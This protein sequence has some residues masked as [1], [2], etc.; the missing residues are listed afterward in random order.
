VCPGRPCLEQALRRG[1]FARRLKVA[2]A[3]TDLET[4]EGLIRERV[5]GKVVSLLGLARR[6]RKVVS[7]AEAVESAMKRRRARLILTA[8]DA[9]A[10]TVDKVLALAR[11]TG[12]ACYRFLSKEELGA[13]VGSAPRSCIVVTDPQFSDALVSILAKCPPDTTSAAPRPAQ[14]MSPHRQAATREAW[15]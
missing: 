11:A 1:E 6:A 4:L 7:G 9:S 14:A 2:L 3:Q 13:A 15:R 10:G 12:T 5:S 8:V